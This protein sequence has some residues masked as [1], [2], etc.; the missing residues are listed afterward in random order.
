MQKQKKIIII[1]VIGLAVLS[2]I[3]IFLLNRIAVKMNKPIA[4]PSSPISDEV[5]QKQSSSEQIARS[6]LSPLEE[7]VKDI[8]EKTNEG[9]TGYSVTS[10][11]D[12]GGYQKQ[13]IK[14]MQLVQKENISLPIPNTIYADEKERLYIFSGSN[15]IQLRNGQIPSYAIPDLR[16]E[17]GYKIYVVRTEEA[18]K[19]RQNQIKKEAAKT[20]VFVN[21]FCLD[22]PFI[23]EENNGV[24]VNLSEILHLLGIEY[25]D[26]E[27]V[28]S[29]NYSINR[30]EL[31]LGTTGTWVYKNENYLLNDNYWS[32]SFKYVRKIDGSFYADKELLSRVL[33]WQILENDAAGIT[34]TTDPLDVSNNIVT[35]INP[36]ED[37]TEE[38]LQSFLLEK[39]A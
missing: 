38:E 10:E 15:I 21:G 16:D 33:G 22:T 17:A 23:N 36:Y 5:P 25:T 19:Q 39:E 6:L 18:K 12:I 35:Y 2:A 29:F 37:M 30:F 34:I 26:D 20:S 8:K 32:D 1:G 28:L 3:I 24:F 13:M 27:L 9:S 4:M 7:V 14:K 11:K 31:E